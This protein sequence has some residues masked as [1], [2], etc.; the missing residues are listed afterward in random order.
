MFNS[1]LV[2][3]FT[4]ILARIDRFINNITMYKLVQFGLIAIAL[5]ALGLSI[6]T[7]LGFGD[8]AFT[9]V[10]LISSL[11]V[12]FIVSYGTNILFGKIFRA[13][14]N[15]ESSV[16]TALILFFIMPPAGVFAPLPESL[17]ILAIV[18]LIA[19][20]SKYVLAI[21]KKHIF[22][23]AAISAFLTG[24]MFSAGHASWWIGSFALLVPTAILG[25]LIVRKIHR[26]RLFF[27]FIFA[28]VI[29]LIISSIVNGT[30]FQTVS[31]GAAGVSMSYSE[32]IPLFLKQLLFSWP[33]VFFA[34]IMLTEP[35]TTPPTK[36]EQA[37]YGVIVGVIFGFPLHIGS[38]Y[39]SPELALIIGNIYVYFVSPKQ[40]LVLMLTKKVEVA[41]NIFHFYFSPISSGR[42][43]IAHTTSPLKF[44]PGQYIEWTLPHEHPDMRGNRR[45]FTI[46]SSPTET[47]V[48]IGVKIIPEHAAVSSSTPAATNASP[49]TTS[50]TT[51]PVTKPMHSSSFKHELLH[52]RER[53][54]K[55]VIVASQV[56]GDFTLPTNQNTPLVFIAG[57]IG[58]TPFRSMIKFLLDTNQKR[59]IVLFYAC[60]SDREFAYTD[61]F[62]EAAKVGVKFVPIITIK[63][64]VPTNWTHGPL[65]GKPWEG[66]AGYLNKDAIEKYVPDFKSRTYYLSGPSAMVD[67][68][69]ALLKT[70]GIGKKNIKTD[71]FPG[72]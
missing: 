17:T 8:F 2:K 10:S 21:H 41:S 27:A 47:E 18:G 23:P 6:G 54:P 71:Y 62:T 3:P 53:D 5:Y 65:Q 9:P 58:V 1:L 29:T 66:Y 33:L 13:P 45:Y 70:L 22:N 40:R 52:L 57:G 39:M 4:K 68:Y 28:S 56:A 25:F 16:I 64:N 59:D 60:L 37:I 48:A 26:A 51:A 24:L 69:T 44:S 43:A 15:S 7:K 31:T 61:I 49:T 34:T 55:S 35:L 32:A 72:F 63:E 50:N 14:L 36:K 20:A 19:M 12:L 46:A 67:S 42:H 30:L 38:I 11:I